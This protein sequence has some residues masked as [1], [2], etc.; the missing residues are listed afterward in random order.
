MKLVLFATHFEADFAIE[1]FAFKQVMEKPFRLYS[2]G[3]A[4]MAVS[5][6]GPVAAALCSSFIFKNYKIRKI[7][8]AGSCGALREGLELGRIF[9]ISK[10]I[11]LDGFC[12]DSFEFDTK[13]LCLAS[14]ATPVEENELRRKFSARADVVDMEAYAIAKALALENFDFKNFQVVKIVSDT[15][16]GCDILA[17]TELVAPKL[18]S[19]IASFLQ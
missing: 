6:I 9:N 14:S 10:I 12:D 5:G 13:G 18:E 15:E 17:N 2:N 7:L 4:L 3:D 11:S 19:T 1:K 16:E 8:N